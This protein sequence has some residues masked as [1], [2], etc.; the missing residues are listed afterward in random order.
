MNYYYWY[1]GTLAMYQFGGKNWDTWNES[2]RDTMYEPCPYCQG[3][4]TWTMR[5][6]YP[7]G[8]PPHGPLR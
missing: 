4:H 7:A 3:S 8:T 2:L 5:D 6:A 1:Y